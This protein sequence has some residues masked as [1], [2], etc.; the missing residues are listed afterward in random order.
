MVKIRNEGLVMEREL[1]ILLIED[2][3]ITCQ[4]FKEYI[5]IT[6][7][8][9][10]IETT[11]NAYQALDFVQEWL[12][13]A[14][15][16]DLELNSG[17]GNGLLFLQRLKQL[18]LPYQ[19]FILITTNNSSNITYNFARQLGADFIMS[20]HQDDYSEKVP[21]DFL[22]MTKEMIQ[23]SRNTSNG[24]NSIS[25]SSDVSVKRI[26]RMISNELDLIGIS[27]KVIGY[28][29]L[30][31]AILLAIMGKNT[32]ICSALADKYKKNDF[33]IER[34]M[35]NAINKAWRTSD[36]DDLLANYKARIN[37]EKGVPTLTE[38]IYYYANKIKNKI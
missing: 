33:S 8:V 9:T 5:D 26:Q 4:A 23:Q 29:Y 18:S 20:K 21:I 15:I 35:Q 31:D 1:T 2:D 37:P 13:D 38:F 22:R 34:A 3:P 32:N 14:I 28:Q 19:P 16:L 24:D 36:I 7:D 6:A 17:K 25:L 27:P 11:N 10:L 12:P 30:S